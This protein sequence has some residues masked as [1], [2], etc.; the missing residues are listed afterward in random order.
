MTESFRQF[1]R[2]R[3]RRLGLIAAIVGAMAALTLGVTGAFGDPSPGQFQLQGDTTQT[4]GQPGDDWNTVFNGSA[5]DFSHT[6]I[7]GATEAPAN[8]TTAWKPSTKVTD[9]INQWSW[10][11]NTSVINAKADITD[12]YA[13]A[14]KGASSDTIM[15]FGLDRFDN[16]G[17][18]SVGFWFL[19][20]PNFS[21]NPDGTFSGQHENGDVFIKSE[22]LQGGGIANPVAYEWQNGSLNAV[23]TGAVCSS[24]TQT[25]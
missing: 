10:Q 7:L 2:G 19:Q 3:G 21:L 22:F 24:S 1:R 6:F 4:A 13:A 16:S 11:T 20:D 18:A 15:Y 17:D 23:V 14:Y 8:D 9:P 5:G 12:A 25:L